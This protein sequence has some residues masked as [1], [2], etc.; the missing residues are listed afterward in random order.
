MGWVSLYVFNRAHH[1]KLRLDKWNIQT[2]R[3]ASKLVK[4][5][6]KIA[7]RGTVAYLFPRCISWRALVESDG[8]ITAAQTSFRVVLCLCLFSSLW[9][10][11]L[12]NKEKKTEKKTNFRLKIYTAKI[13]SILCDLSKNCVVL[14]E[15]W[16]SLCAAHWSPERFKVFLYKCKSNSL[17]KD[18]EIL[19]YLKSLDMMEIVAGNRFSPLSL[20]TAEIEALAWL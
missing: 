18:R 16:R 20:T 10:P 6:M 7:R 5:Q 11:H 19:L 17:S 3:N 2:C 4:W 1:C 14:K 8:K 12:I 15:K 13:N 9:Q